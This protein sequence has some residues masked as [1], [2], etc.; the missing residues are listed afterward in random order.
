MTARPGEPPVALA[1][2]MVFD[3]R[4]LGACGGAWPQP[5]VP[6]RRPPDAL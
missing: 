4:R 5:A 3:T 2:R 1:D 6:R